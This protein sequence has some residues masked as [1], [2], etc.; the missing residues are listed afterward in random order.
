MMRRFKNVP[1][2]ESKKLVMMTAML[3][4]NTWSSSTVEFRFDNNK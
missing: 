3:A 4:V 2:I 1:K